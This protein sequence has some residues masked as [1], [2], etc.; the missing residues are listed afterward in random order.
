MLALFYSPALKLLENAAGD[1][2]NNCSS[3]YFDFFL[4]YFLFTSKANL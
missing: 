4:S 1:K 3:R 2:K